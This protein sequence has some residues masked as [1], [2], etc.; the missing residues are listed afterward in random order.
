[1]GSRIQGWLLRAA[2]RAGSRPGLRL[3]ALCVAAAVPL[4]ATGAGLRFD[5]AFSDRG[6][7]RTLH[8]QAEF[9]AGG[10]QHRVEVWRDGARRLKRRTDE[11]VQFSIKLWT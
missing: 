1:M 7:P 9:T 2:A 4:A 10:V 3:A 6:E 5:Q 11:V 8:Y